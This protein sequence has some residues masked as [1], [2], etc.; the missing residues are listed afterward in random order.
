MKKMN[1][2]SH[3]ILISVMF[4]SYLFRTI[5][6]TPKQIFFGTGLQALKLKFDLIFVWFTLD[7]W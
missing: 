3:Q 2:D 7:P 1:G 4:L 5:G 6:N